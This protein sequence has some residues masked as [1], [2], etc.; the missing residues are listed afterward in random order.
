MTDA[1]D[2][3]SL[4]V[5]IAEDSALIREGVARIVEEA[6][7]VVVA[8]VG[9][10]PSLVEAVERLRPDVSVVDLVALLEKHRA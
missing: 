7:G 10:G 2:E 4:R 9:D 5:V 8:K 3:P 6:G 1:V